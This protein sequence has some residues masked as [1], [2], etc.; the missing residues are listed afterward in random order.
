MFRLSPISIPSLLLVFL[1]ALPAS[2]G[3]VQQSGTQPCRN[4][5]SNSPSAAKPDCV[6]SSKPSKRIKVEFEGLKAFPSS[7]VLKTLREDKAELAEDRMPTQTEIEQA[8]ASIKKLLKTRGYY[9]ASLYVAP[10]NDTLLRVVVN[11]GTR[12]SIGVISFEGNKEISS[13]ELS[14][15]FQQQLA[16]FS[17]SLKAG[18]DEDI[19]DYCHRLL[20]NSVRARGFLQ[21]QYVKPRIT[22]SGTSLNITVPIEEGPTFKLG[23]VSFAGASAFSETELEALFP[24]R[25]GETADG[26]KIG[27]W[28]FE[29]L[30]DAYGDK[31]FIQYT[32]DIEPKFNPNKNSKENGL[33]DLLITIDE[34]SRFKVGSIS[35]NGDQLSP[36]EL[37]SVN[38][39]LLLRTGD[40]FSQKLFDESVKRVN[41]SGIFEGLDRYKDSTFTTDEETSSVGIVFNLKRKTRGQ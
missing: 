35:F 13:D 21:A 11:E 4:S 38:A 7:D 10:I 37:N 33:V 9:D 36:L 17:E 34:G 30:R 40:F 18:Y 1:V 31:G 25:E 2:T 22:P 14:A 8:T 23:K 29:Q 28:L 6:E 39:L 32:A 27:K 3:Q 16:R 5:K 26:E 41:D 15:K 19:F 12:F 20:L 24:I